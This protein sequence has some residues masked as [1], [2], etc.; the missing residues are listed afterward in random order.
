[1]QWVPYLDNE[2]HDNILKWNI[3]QASLFPSKKGLINFAK[4]Q[5]NYAHIIYRKNYYISLILQNII[6]SLITYFRIKIVLLNT[7]L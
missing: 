6:S 5:R 2:L 7:W 1:M 4:S 3:L